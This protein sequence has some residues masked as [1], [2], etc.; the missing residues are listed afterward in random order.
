MKHIHE[1]FLLY[2]F[3]KTRNLSIN[4]RSGRESDSDVEVEHAEKLRQVRAVLEEVK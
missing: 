2:V 3:D 4:F 1:Y